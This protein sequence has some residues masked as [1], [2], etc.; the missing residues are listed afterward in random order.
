[1][2]RHRRK[3]RT[4]Y[5]FK[6]KAGHWKRFRGNPFK[7]HIIR[8]RRALKHNVAMGFYDKTGKFHPIRARA[9]YSEARVGGGGRR[10]KARG[11]KRK[12]TRRKRHSRRRK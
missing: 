12:T 11:R 7:K 8:G 5:V 9:D 2:A 6:K 3:R 1:M 10:V 4:S